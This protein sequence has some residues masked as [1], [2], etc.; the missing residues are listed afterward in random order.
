MKIQMNEKT[1][2]IYLTGHID[3]GNAPVVEV[4]IMKRLNEN[5]PKDLILDAADLE[6][7]SSAG[8]RIVLKLRKKFVNLKV[9]NASNDVYEIFDVTG[10]TELV[11]VEKAYRNF[12][13]SNCELI[14]EGANGWVYRVNGD[15]I[16]KVYKNADSLDDIKRERELSRT[17]FLLGIPTAISFDVV[18]VGDTY[19]V[20]F[21]LLN[22]KSYCELMKED[23]DNLEFC[24]SES[25]RILKTIHSTMAPDDLPHQK[26]DALVWARTVKD[27]FTPEQYEK[28]IALIEA[29][30]DDG[31][32][33]HGDFHLKNIM[34]NND[35]TQLIDMDTLCTGHPIFELAFMFNAYKGFGVL[36]RSS[37]E[38]FFGIPV[39]LAYK[40]WRRSLELYFDTED[41]E[42]LDNIEVKASLIGYLRLMSR[43][44]RKGQENTENGK[45]MMSACRDKIVEALGQV[46]SLTF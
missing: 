2:T 7:I 31:W 29:V 30:P 13:V 43:V 38:N 25:I 18:K 32:L 23:P 35:E 28:L 37:I 41:K 40:L 4:N 34:L 19:G 24:A 44:I 5:S 22:S 39:Q 1:L 12:D 26:D 3:S 8:L 16:V 6:Y 17:A 15:T 9:I 45:Q 27:S 46:D 33:M 10:F 14:G 42:Y 20:V 21:E 36:D 11:D